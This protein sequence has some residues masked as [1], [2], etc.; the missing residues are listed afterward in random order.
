[1][2]SRKATIVQ[3]RSSRDGGV[4]YDRRVMVAA[5]G[6]T[7]PKRTAGSAGPAVTEASRGGATEVGSLKRRLERLWL[8]SPERLWLL[9]IV[10]QQRGHGRLAFAVKQLNTILYHNSLAPKA[11]V[12]PDVRLA[13]YSH[14][15]VI[16]GV[17]IGRN[18]EIWHNVTLHGERRVR[19]SRGRSPDP[20][21]WITIEDHV[22]IGANAVV[23]APRGRGLRIGRGAR[24]GAGTV[25]TED[26][27][28]GA[29]VVGPPARVLFRHTAEQQ[30]QSNDGELP[31]RFR[32]ELS[33]A[34]RSP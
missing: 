31:E 12:S 19:G 3:M 28:P 25:V 32:E 23:I 27:P 21:C 34:E 7:S 8:I 20:S 5:D 30:P 11:S 14:G 16:S 29:T 2:V 10:L 13:H 9:S 17:T 6:N 33:D 15:I 24:I 1:V 26:V 22:K 18:V 4:G